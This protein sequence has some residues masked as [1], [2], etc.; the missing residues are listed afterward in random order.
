MGVRSGIACFPAVSS[1]RAWRTVA[2]RDVQWCTLSIY[3]SRNDVYVVH[4]RTH[5]KTELSCIWVSHW[6]TFTYYC[7]PSLNEYVDAC[8]RS[9]G[10]RSYLPGSVPIQLRKVLKWG[11]LECCV[12][13]YAME[14]VLWAIED[15]LCSTAGARWFVEY[16]LRRIERVLWTRNLAL[17]TL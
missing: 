11:Q 9:W 2:G 16:R 1:G 17:F 12:S 4:V 14:F 5:C 13:W 6:C 7:Q 3:F 8:A 15:V 10:A